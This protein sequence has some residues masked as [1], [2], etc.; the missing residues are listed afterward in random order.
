[1][2]RTAE[3]IL[4]VIGAIAFSIT[5]FIGTMLIILHDNEEMVRDIFYEIALEDPSLAIS[6]ID[7][8]ISVLGSSG[9]VIAIVSFL[10]VALG[11]IAMILLRGNKNP[12][13]AAILFLST[14]II[15]A[16]VSFGIGLLP[17]VFYLIAGIMCLVRKGEPLLEQ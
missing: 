15:I 11:I 1:M 7:S 2:K 5:A 10:A 3:I 12:K 16:L 17:G 6:D 14:S 8:F 4:G 9:W 13:V